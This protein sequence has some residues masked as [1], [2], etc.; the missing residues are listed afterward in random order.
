[1]SNRGRTGRTT[2]G[3]AGFT[4]VELLVVIAIIALLLS[5]LVPSLQG[6]REAARR[7]VCGSH[8]RGLMTAWEAYAVEYGSLPFMGRGAAGDLTV[9]RAGNTLE[10]R[11]IGVF[12]P[13][14]WNDYSSQTTF[15]AGWA[16]LAATTNNVIFQIDKN[17][18]P[19]S[20]TPDYFGT[21]QNFGQLWIRGSAKNPKIF[22]CPSQR[23]PDFQFDT[24]LNPW[25]PAFET[26]FHPTFTSFVNHT[27]AS[28]QRR[29]GVSGVQWDR[30]PTRMF[31]MSDILQKRSYGT[32]DPA[33]ESNDSAS[34]DEIKECHRN[35]INI[36]HRNGGVTFVND[37]P[38]AD[39]E[40]GELRSLS[41][42]TD[43]NAAQQ[44]YRRDLL[45]L[46][47]WLDRR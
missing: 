5:I 47:Y 35:G 6:A 37:V 25:P 26:A 16:A 11:G 19:P 7:S 38:F 9:A 44:Q 27:D 32:L 10:W 40:T 13:G 41:K 45:Q 4:L 17:N 21:W 36:A 12:P 15:G 18:N 30:I 28:F 3:P 34:A 20:P 1:M 8:L 33:S 43:D 23:N 42:W 24:P 2:H 39:Y 46:L 22:F 14:S 29:P 31:V